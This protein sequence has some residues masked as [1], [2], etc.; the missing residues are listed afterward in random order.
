MEQTFFFKIIP[1]LILTLLS[2]FLRLCSLLSLQIK[3]KNASSSSEG[4]VKLREHVLE[5]SFWIYLCGGTLDTADAV[6]PTAG[7]TGSER[8]YKVHWVFTGIFF[9]GSFPS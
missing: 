4:T 7:F 1:Y 2:F 8:G 3:H 6:S 5:V 9:W